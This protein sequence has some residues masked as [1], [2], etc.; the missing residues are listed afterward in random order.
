MPFGPLMSEMQ[1]RL[2]DHYDSDVSQPLHFPNSDEEH[3]EV[4][5]LDSDDSLDEYLAKP[6]REQ[7]DSVVSQ[8]DSKCL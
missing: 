6:T 1:S 5:R 4:P 3:N 2:P 7:I 8:T